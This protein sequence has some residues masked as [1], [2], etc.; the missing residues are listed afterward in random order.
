MATEQVTLYKCPLHGIVDGGDF[1]IVDG[2]AYS[3]CSDEPCTARTEPVSAVVGLPDP[4]EPIGRAVDGED[5]GHHDGRTM[6]AWRLPDPRTGDR[7]PGA[8]TGWHSPTVDVR[9]LPSRQIEVEACGRLTPDEADLFAAQLI[10]AAAAARET[11]GE[12]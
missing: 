4:G 8:P 7:G 12:Q 2:V 1:E 9:D 6:L 10:A 11:G 5:W 3:I